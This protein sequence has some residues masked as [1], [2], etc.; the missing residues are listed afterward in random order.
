LFVPI[1]I[2]CDWFRICYNWMASYAP[3]MGKTI[4]N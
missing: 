1:A 4:M 2:D 3:Y